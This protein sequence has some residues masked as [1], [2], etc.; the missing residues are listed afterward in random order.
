MKIRL[1]KKQYYILKCSF[2]KKKQNQVDTV[3]VG[4]N[5]Y[6]CDECIIKGEELIINKRNYMNFVHIPT[7]QNI[8]YFL[9]QHVIGQH[10]T[11][12]VLSVSVYNH[13]EKLRAMLNKNISFVS[14]N[15]SNILLA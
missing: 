8:K 3:F 10:K 1:K 6:I 5:I 13:Y 14:L 11:K 12:M 4:Y 2:C 9:D 15:K 7:P